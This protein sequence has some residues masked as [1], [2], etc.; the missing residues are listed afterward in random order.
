VESNLLNAALDLQIEP[1]T[2][3][4]NHTPLHERSHTG[5]G[6]RFHQAPYGIYQTAD[7]W[8]SISMSPIDKF[9]KAL[10]NDVLSEYTVKDQMDKREEINQIVISEVLKKTKEEWYDIFKEHEIWFA[11]VN[12]YDEVVED[13][14][15]KWNG[16]I[17]DIEHPDAGKIKLIG[18]PIQY[19]GET[20]PIRTYPP[21]LGEHSK[22]IL[23]QYGYSVDEIEKLLHQGIIVSY[24]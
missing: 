5:L 4:L 18:H 8:I 23:E 13:P 22:Q 15:V 9:A 7:G 10:N 17:M 14:Q 6:S 2:Y 12:N 19:D 24:S 1:L 3:Y 21:R 20:L 16:I 11:P